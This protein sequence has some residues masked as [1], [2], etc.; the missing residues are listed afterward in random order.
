[1]NEEGGDGE[2]A[3]SETPSLLSYKWIKQPTTGLSWKKENGKSEHFKYV[4]TGLLNFVGTNKRKSWSFRN[5][6]PGV[7][8]CCL[9][10]ID[11][12]RA[13]DRTYT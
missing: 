11:K 12:V 2:I 9:L 5:Q 10:S 4:K 1:V 13:T 6:S 3:S 8:D 7:L